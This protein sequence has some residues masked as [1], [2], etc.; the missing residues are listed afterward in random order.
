MMMG[1]VS[2]RRQGALEQRARLEGGDASGVGLPGRL[3]D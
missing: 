1:G 2:V 3:L